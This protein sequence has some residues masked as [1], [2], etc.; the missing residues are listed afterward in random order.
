M[1]NLICLKLHM[2]MVEGGRHG[3]IEDDTIFVTIG[4]YKTRQAHIGDEE[5]GEEEDDDN[6]D[7]G[8]GG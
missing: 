6:V 4:T 3:E 7:V 8:D 5:G 1:G 2:Q